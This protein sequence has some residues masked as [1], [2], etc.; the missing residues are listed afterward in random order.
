[1]RMHRAAILF[2]AA[3]LSAAGLRAAETNPAAVPVPQPGMEA[4]HAQ[5]VAAVK[6]EKFDLILIGDS[7]THTM[8]DY[9][10]EYEPLKKV[11]AQYFAP[12]HALN[13]GYSGARTENILWNLQNGELEGQSPKVVTLMIGTNNADEK[14]YPTHHTAEQ[15]AGGIEAIVKLL[16]QKLPDTKIILLRCFPYGEKPA[17]PANTRNA[18]LDRASELARKSVA[19]EKRVF[20]CDVNRV[21]LKP[22]GTVDKALMP[23]FLHPHG[24]GG[25]RWAAAMEPLLCKLMGDENRALP[26]EGPFNTRWPGFTRCRD[27]RLAQFTK[28]KAGDHGAVVFLGDSITE[29]WNLGKSFPG[30]KAANRGISGDT[31]R[32]M[33]C[34]FQDNVLDLAPKA[35]VLLCGINDLNQKPPGTPDQVAAN[36]RLMLESLKTAAPGTPVFVCEIL[37][38]NSRPLEAIRAANAAVDK[39]VAGFPDARR[40][41]THA[42]FL[43][44]DGTQ[45]LALFTDG[46]HLKPEGYAVW[47][48]ALAPEFEKLGLADANTAVV[49]V[50]KLENDSYDWYARHADV[51]KAG[52]TANPEIVL[53]GDSITHFWGGE[54]KA[55]IV[56]GAKAWASVFG[57]R[58]VLNLG[59]GWDR[60][61]NVLWR[62]D[63]GEFDGLHPRIVIVNIGTN[64]TSGTKNARQNTPE[65]TAEGVHAV[66]DR[67]R[68]K[69][70][71]VKI[72]LMAVFPR[73]EKPDHPRRALIAE[74]NRR[75]AELGKTPGITFLDIGSKLART[76][77]T[78]SREIMSDFCHPSEKG[79][80]I[81]ADALKPVLQELLK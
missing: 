57:G 52:K 72:I 70:P 28:A 75:L 46:T 35:V 53:I 7:I 71:G 43:K 49:P 13:L 17:D 15:I 76:D 65:E 44:P 24:E 21:F 4:R 66:C 29:S 68:A 20:Y 18:I 55:S 56:R 33:L 42:L 54:P 9:G 77:G 51:L 36:V 27:A 67:I 11:W 5:K 47:K 50:P 14:N 25:R 58:R 32:G 38:S 60:T 48:S 26:G 12:R 40:I 10:G 62:L 39:V 81:W 45:N 74:I 78:V 41:R 1:M 63:H 73:E 19:D 31:S 22:D 79:Y 23:D 80:Q 34:R 61:Q 8:G 16:R 69:V 64:N 6:A 37:P 3:V 2:A 59:F 30:L